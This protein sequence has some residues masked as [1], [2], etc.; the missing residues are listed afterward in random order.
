MRT[1]F[2]SIALGLGLVLAG[3]NCSSDD[4]QGDGGTNDDGSP[5]QVGSVCVVPDD[6]YPEV[7]HA[8]LA[9]QVECLDRVRD[10]YC[11]HQCGS[12]AD[13]CAVEGECV[14]DLPQVCSPFESTGLNMCFLS[15]ENEDVAAAGADDAEAFCQHEA[16]PD[17]IC[18]SSGGGS[19]NRKVCVPG[20]CGVGASCADDTHCA[21]DLQCDTAFEGGYCGSRGCGSD[22]DCPA[23]TQ[24]IVDGDSSYCARSCAAE[25]DCTFCRP[26]DVPAACT[27]EVEHV[28]G[29]GTSVCV[30]TPA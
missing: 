13:C 23:D 18:R 29:E 11:T 6:C 14:T 21:A 7:D 10:G 1:A 8:E 15:C 25:T 22:A 3:S 12:D 9:G 28:D 24:C 19:G 2:V 30:A 5:D 20:D 26:E 27:T 17:F 16:S 4:P